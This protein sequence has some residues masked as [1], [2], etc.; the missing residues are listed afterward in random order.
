MHIRSTPLYAEMALEDNNTDQSPLDQF[1]SILESKYDI[2]LDRLEQ[3]Q[4]YIVS[5]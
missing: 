1:L 2:Q 3:R 4:P 5:P